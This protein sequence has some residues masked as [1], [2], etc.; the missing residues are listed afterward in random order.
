MGAAVS[1]RHERAGGCLPDGVVVSRVGT[2]RCRH[3]A[4]GVVS[5][6]P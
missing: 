4:G 1:Y 2:G 3:K 6:R 5:Y